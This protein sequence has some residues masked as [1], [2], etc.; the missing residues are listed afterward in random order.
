MVTWNLSVSNIF[1]EF[2]TLVLA[3][4]FLLFNYMYHIVQHV[5]HYKEDKHGI[6]AS[7]FIINFLLKKR[8]LSCMWTENIDYWVLWCTCQ[9]WQISSPPQFSIVFIHLRVKKNFWKKGA[10]MRFASLLLCSAHIPPASYL[11][12]P[13]LIVSSHAWVYKLLKEV[14]I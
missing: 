1:S 8:K 7:F 11:F 3:Q 12:R 9:I 2:W 4:I 13:C 6:L 14:P 5:A 10:L